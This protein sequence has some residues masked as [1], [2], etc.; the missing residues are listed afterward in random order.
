MPQ[1]QSAIIDI[2]NELAEIQDTLVDML[3]NTEFEH[4]IEQ[5]LKKTLWLKARNS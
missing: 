2:N 5:I 3:I 1:N 4:F